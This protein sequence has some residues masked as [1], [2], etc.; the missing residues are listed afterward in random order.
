MSQPLGI[1]YHLIWTA[2]GWWLPND[3]RGSGSRLIRNDILA[4]LGEL[5]CGRK[6]VQPAGREVR[7]FYEEAAAV[8]QHPL[9]TFD[10]PARSEIGG[11]FASVVED[12]QYTCYACAVMPDHIHLLIR[13]HK[14]RAEEMTGAFKEASRVRLW[15]A[16][17]RAKGHPTWTSGYGWKVFLDH[18]DE[19]RRTITYIERNPL[20]LG[21]AAQ[22]WPFVKTYDG[23]P[24][25][26]GHSPNSPYAKRLR[27][28]GR[29]PD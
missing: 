21:L 26:P 25:Y 17:H 20:P 22:R 7:Q 9:L 12:Q 1:A 3:P 13:K 4:E 28:A 18:P 24:L 8:L 23:W 27:E 11:A 2:Y 5:H 29:L 14:H 15:A 16:G 10:D 6:R 19:V